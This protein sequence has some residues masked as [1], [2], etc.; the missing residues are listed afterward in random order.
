MAESLLPSGVNMRALE[1]NTVDGFQ[2]REKE[3]IL[4][5]L[6]RSND[7]GSLGFLLDLRRINVALTRAKRH[8]FIVG[9]S[10]TFCYHPFYQNLLEYV[11]NLNT[12][13]SSWEFEA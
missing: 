3:A 5:S 10:A 11:Q 13:H 8:L 12:Y 6:T 7:D 9:D 2:G 4:I 1:I